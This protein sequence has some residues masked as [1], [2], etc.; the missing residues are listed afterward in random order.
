MESIYIVLMICTIA[1][2]CLALNWIFC[3][4]INVFIARLAFLLKPFS[5]TAVYKR[6]IRKVKR[7]CRHNTKRLKRRIRNER[8]QIKEEINNSIGYCYYIRIIY[9]ENIDWL[10]KKGFKIT[11]INDKAEYKISWSDTKN[12]P[13]S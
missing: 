3:D 13:Q 12:D 8:N 1:I 11:E 10:K 5:A 6:N 4:E 2:F 9:K 7:N